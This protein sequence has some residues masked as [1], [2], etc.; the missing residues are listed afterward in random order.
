M[1][2]WNKEVLNKLVDKLDRNILIENFG[3]LYRSEIL[4]ELHSKV[5]SYLQSEESEF[6]SKVISSISQEYLESYLPGSKQEISIKEFI[7]QH[8]DDNSFF[9]LEK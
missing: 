7:E 1:I 3:E 4:I 5:K 2:T 8:S 9:F 6:N